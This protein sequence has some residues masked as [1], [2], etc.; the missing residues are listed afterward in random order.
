LIRLG[1]WLQRLHSCG[2]LRGAFR[3]EEA[4]CM[5]RTL[6]RDGRE[7]YDQ[8]VIREFEAAIEGGS[9]E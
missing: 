9:N 1:E 8:E 2:L 6:V 3:P 4:V 5:L 7:K